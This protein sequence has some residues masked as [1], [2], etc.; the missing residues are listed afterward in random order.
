MHGI[1]VSKTEAA[2]EALRAAGYR[3]FDAQP[4]GREF[5]LA[6]NAQT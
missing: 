3:I 1:P 2:L 5:S 6:L 4:T